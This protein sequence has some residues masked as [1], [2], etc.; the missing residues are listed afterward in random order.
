MATVGP[1]SCG[2]TYVGLPERS[3]IDYQVSNIS[4]ICLLVTLNLTTI[5]RVP[6][7]SLPLPPNL[8]LFLYFQS[9]LRVST[10]TAICARN[11]SA[12]LSASFPALLL[13]KGRLLTEAHSS[14]LPLLPEPRLP[15]GEYTPT[16]YLLCGLGRTYSVPCP[17][18]GL[19]ELESASIILSLLPQR[20]ALRP[21]AITLA[22]RLVQFGP[23]R[24]CDYSCDHM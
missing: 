13:A 21:K 5:S 11:L 3:R 9:W 8:L 16:L 22:Q 20:W 23:V 10:S 17:T 6:L 12:G 19:H 14:P 7:T 1:L 18:M 2:F 4:P 15:L 24:V